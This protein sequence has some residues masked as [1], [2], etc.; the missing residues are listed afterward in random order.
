MLQGTRLA[1]ARNPGPGLA[2]HVGYLVAPRGQVTRLRPGVNLAEAALFRMTAVA[3]HGVRLTG[4]RDGELVVVIGQGL[5]GQMSAQAARQR[6]A[7][8]IAADQIR[9]RVEASAKYSA[10]LAVDVSEQSLEEVVRAEAPDGADVVVDTTGNN[11][12]FETCLAVVRREGRIC[13]QGYY[14]DPIA[15][16]FHP[17]HLKRPTVT[18][19]CG[20]DGERDGELA[21]DLAARRTVSPRSSR[22]GSRITTP[23]RP[24]SSSSSTRSA[25]WAW[26][27]V[28]RKPRSR[29]SGQPRATFLEALTAL[30]GRLEANGPEQE[31][32]KR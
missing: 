7:R 27:L 12:M 22:T 21:E 25:A 4:I 31:V 8:V 26:S 18:F 9:L 17:P 23:P 24:I 19:P 14:P 10:D 1:D 6:G 30:R 11:R 2:S 32:G 5:I 13:L 3:R 15:I 20:W 16:D 28:G 29:K